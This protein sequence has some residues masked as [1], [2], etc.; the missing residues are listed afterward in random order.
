[1]EQKLRAVYTFGQPLAAGVLAPGI[2]ATVGRKLF[3]HILGRDLM[4]SL[5]PS[6]WGSLRHFGHEFQYADG[7]WQRRDGVTAQLAG[8]REASRATLALLA[9][10]RKRDAQRY[11][12]ADHGPHQYIAALRPAGRVTELG[13]LE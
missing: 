9:P 11:T 13:D 6:V 5:P 8:F 12:M 10:A 2:A 3:R 7:R 1:V 4:P